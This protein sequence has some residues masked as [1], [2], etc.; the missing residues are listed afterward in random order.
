MKNLFELRFQGSSLPI[1]KLYAT[2]DAVI[3]YL[4][5]S[6]NEPS[7]LGTKERYTN[8]FEM[9]YHYKKLI[10]KKKFKKLFKKWV[11][12]SVN[13]LTHGCAA[14]AYCFY[15]ETFRELWWLN[16]ES[17]DAGY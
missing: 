16:Y 14:A 9:C 13:Y 6:H 4:Y 10:K 15:G 11:A 8:F 17:N 12:F 2:F 1:V 3:L 7:K 5:C